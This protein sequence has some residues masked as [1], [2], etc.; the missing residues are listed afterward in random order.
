VSVGLMSIYMRL[1]F[2]STALN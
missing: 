2:W 1:S